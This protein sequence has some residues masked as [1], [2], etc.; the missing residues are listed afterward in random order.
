MKQTRFILVRHGETPWNKE[1]RYQGQ[2][3]TPLSPV[4]IHQGKL[5]AE[6]L[7]DIHIDVCYSSPL[8]RAF[9]TASMCAVYHNMDVIQDE[10]LLEINHGTWE[11]RLAEEIKEEYPELLEKWRTTV[12]DVVMPGGEA[13]EDVRKRAMQAFDEYTKI[14]QG[15]TVLVVA[16]DAVNKAV[17]CDVLG[18]DLSKFWQV[19]QDNTCINVIEFEEK[20]RLVLMNATSHLGFLFSGIEQ[21]GL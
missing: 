12:V 8:S 1:G 19:K 21:K 18:I 7:K 5:V 9:D 11:G 10:R 13:I 15:Q 14:H 2:I 17:L 3:D 20:W 16:H 4:G 6:A